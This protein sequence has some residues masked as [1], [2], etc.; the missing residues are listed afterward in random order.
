MTDLVLHHLGRRYALTIERAKSSYGIPVLVDESGKAYG[1]GD[2]VSIRDVDDCP[3]PAKT[4]LAGAAVSGVPQRP[5]FEAPGTTKA[6][7]AFICH[8]FLSP[9]HR[10]AIEG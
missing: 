6:R 9:L 8:G 4:G 1:P 10:S 3:P 2:I 5:A 7:H